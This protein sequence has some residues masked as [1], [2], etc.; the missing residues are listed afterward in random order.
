MIINT[1][2]SNPHPQKTKKKKKT[3]IEIVDKFQWL[4]I[5]RQGRS[6]S[7]EMFM[8]CFFLAQR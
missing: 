4:L 3:N 5:S 8:G 7:W 2:L 1:L 6:I